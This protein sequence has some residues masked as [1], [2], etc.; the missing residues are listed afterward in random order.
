MMQTLGHHDHDIK[1][2][3]NAG[4]LVR[5]GPNELSF[6]SL[7]IY[8]KVHAPGSAFA[9]DS[10]VYGQFVQDGHPALF[11]ITWVSKYG[12]LYSEF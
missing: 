1:F 9:K 4:P 7:D 2:K 3:F 10:R 5:I 6:Y 8:K 11:S 12:L